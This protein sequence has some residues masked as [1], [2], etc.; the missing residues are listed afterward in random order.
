M[1]L[2]RVRM[3][4]AR[5]ADFPEGSNMRGYDFIVPLGAQNRPDASIW[6]R[7]TKDCLVHRFWEGEDDRHGLLRH[8]GGQWLVDYDLKREGDEEPFVQLDRHPIETGNYLSMVEGDGK[9][10]TFHIVSVK[11]L[12]AA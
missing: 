9:Q 10:R 7:H 12:A 8:T 6:K 1:T 11:P 3:T 4:L 5:D 2:Y